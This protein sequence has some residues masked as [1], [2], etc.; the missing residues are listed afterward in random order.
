[1]HIVR[2]NLFA[3]RKSVNRSICNLIF[4][5]S[6]GHTEIRNVCGLPCAMHYGRADLRAQKG[7]GL[8]DVCDSLRLHNQV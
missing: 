7:A 6:Q 2:L 1:M 8:G 3:G 4:I 5:K